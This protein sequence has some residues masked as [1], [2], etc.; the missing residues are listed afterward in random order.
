MLSIK[1]IV[2]IVKKLIEKLL[3]CDQDVEVVVSSSNYELRNALV[4]VS[5]VHQYENGSKR[6][7]TFTDDFDNEDYSKETW[8]IIGGEIPVILIG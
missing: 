8:S 3:M 5:M 1:N 2:M 7:E 4:P 6:T